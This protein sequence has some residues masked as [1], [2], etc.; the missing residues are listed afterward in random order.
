MAKK[1]SK[2]EKKDARKYKKADK[3]IATGNP[4]KVKKYGYNHDAADKA[5]IKP[6]ETGHY[7]SRN[8]ETGEILKGRKHPTIRK[9]RKAEKAVGN[10]VF[11]VK[12]GTLYS[13]PKEDKIGKKA[14]KWAYRK[15]IKK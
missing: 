8:P 1:P 7:P 14:T 11:K 15:G 6:D 12:G 4:K 13:L 5:G 10:K 3:K 9:T 2:E